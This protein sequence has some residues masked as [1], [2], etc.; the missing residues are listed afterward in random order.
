MKGKPGYAPKNIYKL[1]FTDAFNIL[2][3]RQHYL[4]QVLIARSDNGYNL[5]PH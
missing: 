1:K 4:D 3:L 5:S 2:S